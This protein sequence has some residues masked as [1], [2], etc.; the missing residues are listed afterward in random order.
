[1]SFDV[2]RALALHSLAA[3][4]PASVNFFLAAFFAHSVIVH[5]EDPYGFGIADVFR[6]VA[7]EKNV[8]VLATVSLPTGDSDDSMFTMRIANAASQLRDAIRNPNTGEPLDVGT[9]VYLGSS[10]STFA[11]LL[12][13]CEKQNI[14]GNPYLWLASDGGSK[15]FPLAPVHGARSF[16]DSRRCLSVRAPLRSDVVRFQ[17]DGQRPEAGDAARHARNDALQ[18]QQLDKVPGVVLRAM[19][20]AIDGKRV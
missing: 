8:S 17:L 7:D 1:M 19:G 20:R 16:I 4:L 3:A 6:T 5:S 10:S 11:R 14:T 13:A 12:R 18:Q 9:F 2:A 15:I